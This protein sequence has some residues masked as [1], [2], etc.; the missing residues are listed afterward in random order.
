MPEAVHDQE[1]VV[2]RSHSP[3]LL[4]LQRPQETE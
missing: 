2:E 1:V 4:R 3:M